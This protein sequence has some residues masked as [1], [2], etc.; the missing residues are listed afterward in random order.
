VIRDENNGGGVPRRPTQGG[1]RTVP[2]PTVPPPPADRQGPRPPRVVVV[3]D[4]TPTAPTA[5]PIVAIP[6]FDP[7]TDPVVDSLQSAEYFF[8]TLYDDFS[9]TAQPVYNF[10]IPGEESDQSERPFESPE[11]IPRYV[12]LRWF[13]APDYSVSY[14]IKPRGTKTE[15]RDKKRVFNVGGISFNYDDVLYFSNV[16]K[17]SA[18][19][20]YD[21]GILDLKV[22]DPAVRG[23]SSTVDEELYL[24]LQT[25]VP[26]VDLAS[27]DRGVRRSFE[28]DPYGS[29][30]TAVSDAVDP[31]AD[32]K[33]DDSRVPDERVRMKVSVDLAPD[34]LSEGVV[35]KIVTREA[36]EVTMAVSGIA[37]QIAIMK[38]VPDS[39]AALLVEPPSIPSPQELPPVEYVGYIIEKYVLERDGSF[40]LREVIEV[41]DPRR[42]FY[43]DQKVAYGMVVRYRMLAV[44][45]WT[46]DPAVR[47]IPRSGTG[48]RSEGVK[49]LL[50][51]TSHVIFSGWSNNAVAAVRDMQPPMPPEQLFVR[52]DSRRGRIQV[53]W[54]F[55]DDDQNDISAFYLHRRSMKDGVF[56]SGWQVV[57]GPLR[58]AN[59]SF[60]DE[61]GFLEDRSAGYVYA[62]TSTSVHDE[63]SALSEQIWCSLNR[64]HKVEGERSVRQVSQPGATL[65]C[66]GACEVR[67]FREEPVETVCKRKLLLHQRT[68]TS[69]FVNQDSAITLR[70]ESLDTGETR[71]VRLSLTNVSVEAP[72]ISLPGPGR[73]PVVPGL[74]S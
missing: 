9:L 63:R 68:G 72:K 55:P 48:A 2:P 23:R 34:L 8:D 39:M 65:D 50:A 73:I 22:R 17:L 44:M 41:P 38:T 62:M 52:P 45:R 60:F 35:D 51:S 74:L 67:P 26:L 47:I 30:A 7:P 12:F 25:S 70:L 29:E 37:G 49:P 19:G 10:F 31:L 27:N 40:Q 66:H 6:V 32:V 21:S 16:R 61:V 56:T 43:I 36:A 53:A 69:K 4:P 5:P 58:P 11:D 59:G 57:A 54:V 71:D 1:G 14:E 46:H 20:F 3:V 15:S 18:N 28:Y 13:P 42:T 33:I 24:G 64:N